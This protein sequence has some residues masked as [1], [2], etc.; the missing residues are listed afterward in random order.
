MVNG[1]RSAFVEM[2]LK[3]N[4]MDE[5]SKQ[6]TVEKVHAMRSFI[7]FPDWLFTPGELDKYYKKVRL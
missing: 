6:R 5:Q 1:V 2:A 3:F 4:W 7:S